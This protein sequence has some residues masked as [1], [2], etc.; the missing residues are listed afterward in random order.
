M[1]LG[2]PIGHG[3]RFAYRKI[4]NEV[5]DAHLEGRVELGT[6]VKV[7]EYLHGRDHDFLARAA[8]RSVQR[9][10]AFT[11]ETWPTDKWL[12][13]TKRADAY[14][15]AEVWVEFWGQATDKKWATRW[16]NENTRSARP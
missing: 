14:K 10:R 5:R 1:P 12:A 8:N 15:G 3:R 16:R 6:P 4:L 7:G 11:A 9:I 2:T 13:Y